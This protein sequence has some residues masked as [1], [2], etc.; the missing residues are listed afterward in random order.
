M[1]LPVD[2]PTGDATLG[3]I[4]TRNDEGLTIQCGD[5][6]ITVLYSEPA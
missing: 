1:R 2:A 6:P 4:I 3:T 5:G